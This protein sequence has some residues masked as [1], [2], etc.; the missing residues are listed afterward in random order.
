AHGLRL[1]TR[2]AEPRI[3][4]WC[5]A[6]V[7][8]VFAAAWWQSRDRVVGTLQPGAP[9]LREDSRFNRDAVAIASNFDT[10]LDWLTVVFEAQPTVGSMGLCEKVDIGLYQDR[11]TW[12]MQPVQGVLSVASFAGQLRLYNEGYNEGHPKMAVVPIDP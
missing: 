9:E 12:A 3:A 10:G 8:I 5:L 2:V 4:A 1:L 11:F 7:G 6:I